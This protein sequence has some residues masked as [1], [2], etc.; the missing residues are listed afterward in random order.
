MAATSS[1]RKKGFFSLLPYLWAPLLLV[2]AF[3]A[4]LLFLTTSPTLMARFFAAYSSEGLHGISPSHYPLLAQ[5]ITGYLNGSVSSMDISLPLT[6]ISQRVF[7]QKELMHM[8]DIAALI[9]LGKKVL[10]AGSIFVLAVLA[11]YAFKKKLTLLNRAL[12]RCTLIFFILLIVLAL[13][14][15]I[16]FDSLFLL[17]HRL[18]FT[19]DL[20]LLNPAQDR[21][22]QL[23]PLPF[24][25][26]YGK[27]LVL[28]YV[29]LLLVFFFVT[30][31]ISRFFSPLKE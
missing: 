12:G 29:L 14:V 16:D 22:I 1:N 13:W 8:E 18:L 24:F 20:W 7:N 31:I 17:F 30:L 4:L 26:A 5:N 28:S 23:M 25:I 27:T 19:N 11:F 3:I 6:G 9:A 21:L 10:A 15:L 2:L